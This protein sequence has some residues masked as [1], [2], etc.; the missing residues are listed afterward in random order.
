MNST[1]GVK[2]LRA[3]GNGEAVVA[4]TGTDEGKLA[5]PGLNFF[6]KQTLRLEVGLLFFLLSCKENCRHCINAAECLECAHP[7]ATGFIFDHKLVTR[8][9]FDFQK[10]GRLVHRALPGQG[11][12]AIKIENSWPIHE[13]SLL[14][15]TTTGDWSRVQTK[16]FIKFATGAV[17]TL[18]LS[19]FSIQHTLSRCSSCIL[20]SQTV[21]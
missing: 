11:Q 5:A 16:L 15:I 1:A 9:R 4:R 21:R 19:S 10:R 14:E 17:F 6:R 18:T 13:P 3:P 12:S 7:E 20:P 2:K 8:G